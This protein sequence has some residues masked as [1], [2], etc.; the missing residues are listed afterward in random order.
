M[1]KINFQ[2]K[3]SETFCLD[4][5]DLEL[6]KNL[7]FLIGPNGSGKSTLLKELSKK[8]GADKS[9][10]MPAEFELNSNLYVW[11]LLEIFEQESLPKHF[12]LQEI[13]TNTKLS[14]LSSGGKQRLLLGL[15][16]EHPNYSNLLLDEPTNFLD[17]KYKKQLLELIK[18]SSKC[19]LI[20]SH[21]LHWFVNDSQCNTFLINDGKIGSRGKLQEVLEGTDMKSFF[22]MDFKV[23]KSPDGKVWL[24]Y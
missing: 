11:E 14:K 18:N 19:I 12:D 3:V 21:D 6:C 8:L 5:K 4:I 17:P 13:P 22:G 10:Y 1:Q 24:K 2:L 23:E 20:A 16:L 7:N 15:C 9:I